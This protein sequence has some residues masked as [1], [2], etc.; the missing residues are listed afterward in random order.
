MV[1]E[2][3]IFS[4]SLL[5]IAL[6]THPNL[7]LL[8][9]ANHTFHKYLFFLCLNILTSRADGACY[10]ERMAVMYSLYFKLLHKIKSKF[11]LLLEFKL[12][13]LLLFH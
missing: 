1:L 9:S 7:K 12:L 4:S 11:S 10:Y 3:L 5:R 13:Y 8:H 6:I 2:H